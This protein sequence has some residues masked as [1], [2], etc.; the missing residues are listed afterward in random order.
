MYDLEPN[1][2]AVDGS[3]HAN[4]QANANAVCCTCGGGNQ[5]DGAANPVVIP[6]FEALECEDKTLKSGLEWTDLL[7]N[8]CAH[9]EDEN[10]CDTEGSYNRNEKLVANQACCACNGG[11][12]LEAGAVCEDKP[13]PSDG[14]G[15]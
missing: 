1:K 14:N 2:C 4:F 15:G 7:G 10:I 13:G 8:N 11:Q 3:L 12:R 6:V 9:Y 5:G